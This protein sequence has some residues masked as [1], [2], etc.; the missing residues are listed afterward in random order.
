MT[1]A[2]VIAGM[3]GAGASG[4]SA[5]S[6]AMLAAVGSAIGR[7]SRHLAAREMLPYVSSR[8]TRAA[9]LCFSCWIGRGV[10][11]P[12]SAWAGTW[13]AS[14]RCKR[15]RVRRARPRDEPGSINTCAGKRRSAEIEVRMPA[16]MPVRTASST[17]STLRVRVQVHC[18]L[19]AAGTV[20][21]GLTARVVRGGAGGG[22]GGAGGG[23]RGGS[24]GC[25][26]GKG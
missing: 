10:N 7:A 1:A 11:A 9:S 15:A 16:S 20:R 6:T 17:S 21:L 2:V 22:C 3:T 13:S 8:W 26:A 12:P 23:S 19:A 14:T 25:S 5:W 4:C 18:S 24:C